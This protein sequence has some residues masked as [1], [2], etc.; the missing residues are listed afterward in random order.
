MFTGIIEQPARVTAT[1]DH[2]GGRRVSVSHAWTDLRHGESIAINGCCLTVAEFDDNTVTFDVITE[3][4]DKTNLRGISNGDLL[5]VERALAANGRLDGHFVQG[6]IDATAELVHRVANDVEWRLRVRVPEAMVKYLMPK[7]SVC[8]DGVSLTIADLSD[9]WFEVTLIPT[10]LDK[11]ALGQRPIG[12][13]FNF[14]ADILAKTIVTHLERVANA[15]A[16]K[17]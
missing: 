11:T 3:T 9:D 4:L 8:I 5:H 7:G 15:Q 12:Y 10:T 2:R 14:E 6:H 17:A 13:R 16:Q 1:E